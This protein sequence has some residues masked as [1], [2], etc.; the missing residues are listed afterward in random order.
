VPHYTRYLDYA[1]QVSDAAAAF[2]MTNSICQGQQASEIW[3]VAFRRDIEI[4]FA[5]TSFKW[6]NLASHNAG[7]TVIIVGLCRKSTRPKRLFDD[8]SLVRECSVSVR[9]GS[10]T[11]AP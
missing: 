11:N 1:E 9:N 6:S 10:P 4:R 7:V 5:H 3:P 2:V 8:A